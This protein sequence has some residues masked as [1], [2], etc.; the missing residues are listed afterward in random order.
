MALNATGAATPWRQTV[1]DTSKRPAH[2]KAAIRAVLRSD[3][4]FARASILFGSFDAAD[5]V[6]RRRQRPE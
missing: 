1:N 4:V 6:G 5:H 2:E 3:S